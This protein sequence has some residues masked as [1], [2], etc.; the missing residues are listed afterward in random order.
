[1]MSSL[2]TNP[3]MSIVVMFLCR[4]IPSSDLKRVE[5]ALSLR[6]KVKALM[7]GGLPSSL[8]HI[9]LSSFI[10]TAKPYTSSDQLLFVDHRTLSALQRGT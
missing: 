8:T 3:V 6:R 5:W 10:M 2:P 9:C 1:M 7:G 4:N